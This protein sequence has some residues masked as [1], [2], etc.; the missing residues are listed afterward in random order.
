MFNTRRFGFVATLAIVLMMAMSAATPALGASTNKVVVVNAS[1]APRLEVALNVTL[2]DFG[3]ARSMTYN[4]VTRIFGK[5]HQIWATVTSNAPYSSTLI[6]LE[7]SPP[8]TG[9]LVLGSP[10]TR[11]NWQ[12]DGGGNVDVVI[13]SNGDAG[14]NSLVPFVPEVGRYYR[15]GW[16]SWLV[17]E[18]FA[19]SGSL[20]VIARFQVAQA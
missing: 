6:M 9:G 3:E 12:I 8:S 1:Y 5:G 15:P 14:L 10:G 18:E 2:I 11:L 13:G 7:G 20:N 19:S 17:F 16:F 4:P